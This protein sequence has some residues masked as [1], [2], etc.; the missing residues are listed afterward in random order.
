MKTIASVFLVLL[1]TSSLLLTNPGAARADNLFVS[2]LAGRVVEFG[3]SA[4][5]TVF[6]T[7]GTADGIAFDQAGN[8]YAT[9]SGGIEK[10]NSS[11]TMTSIFSATGLSEP[12]ALTFDSAGTLFVSDIFGNA[13]WKF[14]SSGNGTLFAWSGLDGPDGLAFD[15]A[16]NLYVANEGNNTIEEFGT[17]GVGRVFA[18]TGLNSPRGLAFDSAGNL[19]VANYGNST[20]EV[21]NTNAVGT[22][23]ASSGVAWPWGLA[24]DR[25]GNLY[26]AN[27]LSNN[28]E[29]FNPSGVGT[30]F[31][32]SG[33]YDPAALA[34]ENIPEPSPGLL[35]TVSLAAVLPLKR[36]RN[37]R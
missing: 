31:V 28:I 14:N 26:V 33:L 29:E 15:R 7:T 24:L 8:L 30:V 9:I 10:L 22:V 32:S 17:N 27:Q 16:G 1:S 12:F 3:P 37:A 4:T 11:G 2:D 13:I 19:Y 18:N 6:A 35:I 25:A 36:R 23:F 20:I 5:G 34:F 21:F